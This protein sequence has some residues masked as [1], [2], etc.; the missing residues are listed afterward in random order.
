MPEPLALGLRENERVIPSTER[1]ACPVCD[2]RD[3]RPL[4]ILRDRLWS[5]PGTFVM[6]RCR[7]CSH[8][9]LL[10]RP[11]REGMGAYYEG[12]Y[13]AGGLRLEEQLQ[14]SPLA[15]A[16]NWRRLRALSARRRSPSGA[17]HLDVGCGVSALLAQLARRGR[18]AVGLDFDEAACASQRFF[19]QGQ[20]VQLWRGTLDEAFDAAGERVD[21]ERERFASASL[22]HY[23]E[24]TYSPVED[25]RRVAGLLEAGGAV[26]IEVPALEAFNRRLFRPFWLPYL[27]PQHLSLWT[28]ASLRRALEE[29]GFEGVRIR[30]ASAPFVAFSSFLIWWT[31]S[32][33]RKSRVPK[34]AQPLLLP[35]AIF[36]GAAVLAGDLAGF[37]WLA[38]TGRADHLRATAVKK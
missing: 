17:R 9:F 26:V 34:A 10:V 23:L 4:Q 22:I 27:P 30:G 29:A 31:W 32:F 28:R 38:K 24:H 8:G 37:W 3:A 35:L 36:L 5:R 18:S 25:L 13:D 14:R 33:G 12:L 7:A 11:T 20:E 2:A 21:F 6:A 16:L 19:C 15:R 1:A